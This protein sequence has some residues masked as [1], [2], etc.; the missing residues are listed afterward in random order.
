MNDLH[1]ESNTKGIAKSI[2]DLPIISAKYDCFVSISNMLRNCNLRTMCSNPG[3]HLIV[4]SR[5]INFKKHF[6]NSKLDLNSEGSTTL[7]CICTD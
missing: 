1:S 2:V 5:T 6:E 7:Q 3:V 4:N